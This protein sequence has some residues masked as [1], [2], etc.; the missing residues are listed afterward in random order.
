MSWQRIMGVHAAAAD[1]MRHQEAALARV[2][3]LTAR[4]GVRG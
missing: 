2:S 4:R 1:G 3:E